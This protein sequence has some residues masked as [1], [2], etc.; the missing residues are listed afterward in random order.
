MSA[1]LTLVPGSD[2]LPQLR[3]LMPNRAISMSEARSIAERQAALLLDLSAVTEPWVPQHII[4]S[5]P[6]IVVEWPRDWP[7]DGTSFKAVS[8][9]R[10]VIRATDSV[11][12][13]RFSLAHELKHVLD[14]PVIDRL[15][16]HVQAEKRQ[17]RAEQ[18]CHYFAACLLMPRPWVKHDYYGG[19]QS[20]HKL[21]RRYFVSEVAMTKRLRELGLTPLVR[22][23]SKAVTT[24]HRKAA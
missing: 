5:L 18:L 3:Q 23:T 4:C 20:V 19:M 16:T 14:D 12:R 7:A 8:H 2:L 1:A 9:W 6:G 10:I 22:P 15:H 17:E 11:Q 24:N 21:A 13:Q